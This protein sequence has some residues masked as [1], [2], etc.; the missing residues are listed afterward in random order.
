MNAFLD[1]ADRQ[2][3]APIR[4]RQRAVEKR[5]ERKGNG[6]DYLI[7]SWRQWR[8]EPCEIRNR[9]ALLASQQ[10]DVARALITFLASMT[11]H[12]G[13]ALVELVKAGPWQQADRDTRFEILRLIDAAIIALREAHGLVPF[14]D[15]LPGEPASVFLLIRE[16]LA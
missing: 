1:L 5:A 13:T 15:A 4:A 11:L 6:R 12:D 9:C 7:S 16:A 8:D 3:A 14:D 10:G 2:N